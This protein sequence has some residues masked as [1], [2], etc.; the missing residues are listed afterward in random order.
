MAD[1]PLQYAFDEAMKRMAIDVQYSNRVVDREQRCRRATE[2][3]QEEARNMVAEAVLAK[4]FREAKAPFTATWD[5]RMRVVAL[6]GPFAQNLADFEDYSRRM[7]A[8]LKE[9]FP[10]LFLI[11]ITRKDGRWL[12]RVEERDF[13]SPNPGNSNYLYGIERYTVWAVDEKD[14]TEWQMLFSLYLN[15]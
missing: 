3:P 5:D 7:R 4:A 10:S 13:Y 8:I 15:K 6:V 1:D 14:D 11:G 9:R 2:N 12:T